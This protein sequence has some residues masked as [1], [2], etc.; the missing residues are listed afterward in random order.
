MQVLGID[1]WIL[2]ISFAILLFTVEIFIPGFWTAVLAIGALTAAIP[3]AFEMS[4]NWQLAV[5]ATVSFLS[6]ILL[7]PLVIKYLYKS[8][9]APPSNASALIGKKVKITKQINGSANPGKVKIGS[10]IWKALPK[11]ESSVYNIDET[12]EIVEVN[13]AKVTVDKIN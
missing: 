11:D 2:W 6:G 5:F 12:V 3:A 8:E 9:K 7:R 13:G 4:I 10:E 1:V